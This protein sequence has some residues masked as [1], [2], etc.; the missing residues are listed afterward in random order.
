MFKQ[1]HRHSGVIYLRLG[2]ISFDASRE[3][4]DYVL[5]HYADHLD[6]F[7]VVTQNIVRVRRA[8]HD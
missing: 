3:R 6:Q 7:I 8:R 2:T 5:T 1:H 4:L